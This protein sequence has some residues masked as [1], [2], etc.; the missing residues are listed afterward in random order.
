MGIGQGKEPERPGRLVK[1]EQESGCRSQAGAYVLRDA[2]SGA[3]TE[4]PSLGARPRLSEVCAE[5]LREWN[6][7]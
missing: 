3:G 4:M 1:R 5:L 7:E 2:A 6:I